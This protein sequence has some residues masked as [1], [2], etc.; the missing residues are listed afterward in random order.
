MSKQRMSDLFFMALIGVMFAY[1]L[2]E[3]ITG[4]C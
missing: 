4:P 1:L 2:L 3:W